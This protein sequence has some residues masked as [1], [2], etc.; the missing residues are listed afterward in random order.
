MSSAKKKKGKG[1]V[2]ITNV[3]VTKETHIRMKTLADLWH[4]SMSEVINKLIDEGAPNVDQVIREREEQE[5]RFSQQHKS[6][7][8]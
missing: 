6:N 5:R 2:V 4:M 1:R 3:R 8:N 7:E